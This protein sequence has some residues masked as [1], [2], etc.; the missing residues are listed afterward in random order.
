MSLTDNTYIVRWSPWRLLKQY[1]LLTS[2][3]KALGGRGP[4]ETPK[5]SLLITRIKR[6]WDRTPSILQRT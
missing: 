5:L 3:T 1:S 4:C 2:L 6:P